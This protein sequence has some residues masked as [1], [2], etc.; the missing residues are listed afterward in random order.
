MLNDH[1]FLVL[2]S[3]LWFLQPS[4]PIFCDDL[5]DLILCVYDTVVPSG[6]EC[7]TLTY[8]LHFEIYKDEEEHFCDTWELYTIQNPVPIK[9][10]LTRI[11][12]SSFVICCLWLLLYSIA[13]LNN[14]QIPSDPYSIYYLIYHGKSQL[15]LDL[16]GQRERQIT[17]FSVRPQRAEPSLW[18]P[19][20]SLPCFSPASLLLPSVLLFHIPLVLLAPEGSGGDRMFASLCLSDCPLLSAQ[21][22]TGLTVTFIP[23][24]P[25]FNC[26]LGVL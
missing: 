21:L 5:W 10:S 6:A 25:L 20:S 26:P 12:P 24:R 14:W 19:T 17:Q 13:E 15:V 7:S 18:I 1:C 4:C 8:F 22:F 23:F 3:N 2:P 16:V 9:Q 11:L